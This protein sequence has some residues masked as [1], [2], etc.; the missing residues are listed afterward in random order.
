[1]YEAFLNAVLSDSLTWRQGKG[2]GEAEENFLQHC[3]NI[4]PDC[5][6]VF[7]IRGFPIVKLTA[8]KR[9]FCLKNSP[10]D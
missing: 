2:F 3:A 8:L 7:Y 10:S 5:L 4:Y 9:W 1:V 6:A